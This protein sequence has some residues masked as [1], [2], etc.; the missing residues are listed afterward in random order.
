M[1]KHQQVEGRA[2]VPVHC[3]R[4]AAAGQD[5]IQSLLCS[6]TRR[7]PQLLSATPFRRSKYWADIQL[8]IQQSIGRSLA[9]DL[10]LIWAAYAT[11]HSAQSCG[12]QPHPHDFEA[13]AATLSS[14]QAVRMRLAAA[15]ASQGWGV[16]R[17]FIKA[18][19][20]VMVSPMSRSLLD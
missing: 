4:P 20:S 13:M 14:F 16:L 11:T 19:S 9:G 18:M 7:R 3:S 8:E 10:A 6:G 2:Y 12:S 15:E 1:V 5:H 17:N